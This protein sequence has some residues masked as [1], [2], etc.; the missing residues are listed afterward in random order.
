MKQNLLVMTQ[1][2]INLK[3][4]TFGPVRKAVPVNCRR[5]LSFT[6]VELL[7]VIAIIAILAGLLLPALK[8]AKDTAKNIVCVNNLKQFSTTFAFYQ[9]DFNDWLPNY[10]ENGNWWRDNLFDLGY[11]PPRGIKRVIGTGYIPG[12]E[13]LYCPYNV[14]EFLQSANYADGYSYALPVSGVNNVL[15]IGGSSG[16]AG[17]A[18]RANYIKSNPSMTAQLVEILS[19]DKSKGQRGYALTVTTTSSIS[20]IIGQHPK[21]GRNANILQA[22]GSVSTL[23]GPNSG[24]PATLARA[25][26][27]IGLCWTWDKINNRSEFPLNVKL[28]R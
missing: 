3:T 25:E 13:K 12:S 10:S 9:N 20:G 15:A 1:E 8:A 23:N 2:G 22:D 24:T 6:L 5:R 19:S 11:I 17:H 14:N 26:S 4:Q 18:P 27:N 28:G 16:G 21:L 7:V